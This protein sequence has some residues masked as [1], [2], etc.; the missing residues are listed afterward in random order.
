[1]PDQ[2]TLAALQRLEFARPGAG[3]SG[4]ERQARP[5][6]M[7]TLALI[8]SHAPWTPIPPV[9]DWADVGDGSVFGRYAE[10]GDPPAVVWRDTGRV[11]TQYARSL[12][13][14]LRTLAAFV[15]EHR[16]DAL[17]PVVPGDHQPA[18]LTPGQHAPFA[19][20]LPL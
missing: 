19:V 13:Y 20:P 2:Y 17:V 4:P 1:M 16:R 7:A 6:V 8:S 10:A 12:D 3:K 11:R 18:P 14:V 15:P 5:P 9:I